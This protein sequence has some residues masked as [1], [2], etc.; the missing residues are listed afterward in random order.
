M[1]YCFSYAFAKSRSNKSLKTKIKL[2]ALPFV[3]KTLI[4]LVLSALAYCLVFKSF[5][6]LLAQADFLLFRFRQKQR[7][8]EGETLRSISKI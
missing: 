8:N 4:F 1:P 6:Q 3:V 7:L 2:E 5:H